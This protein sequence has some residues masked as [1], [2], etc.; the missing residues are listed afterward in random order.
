MNKIIVVELR[1]VLIRNIPWSLH[2]YDILMWDFSLASHYL[3]WLL[4][5]PWSRNEEQKND[6]L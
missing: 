2:N 1:L 5:W 3:G 4:F 6:F